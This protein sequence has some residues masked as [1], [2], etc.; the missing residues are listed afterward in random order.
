MLVLLL[1]KLLLQLTKLGELFLTFSLFLSPSS[2]LERLAKYTYHIFLYGKFE[3]KTKTKV[4]LLP[5]TLERLPSHLCRIC[6]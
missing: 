2:D 4:S 1:G 3:C 5:S 6:E